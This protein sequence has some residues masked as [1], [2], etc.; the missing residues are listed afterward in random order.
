MTERSKRIGEMIRRG[1][2]TPRGV[3][4]IF[5]LRCRLCGLP[6]LLHREPVPAFAVWPLPGLSPGGDTS[7]PFPGLPVVDLLH[8]D[9]PYSLSGS[10]FIHE[11]YCGA[12]LGMTGSSSSSPLQSLHCAIQNLPEFFQTLRS[13]QDPAWCVCPVLS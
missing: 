13:S 5:L 10:L 9:P 12:A 7:C 4:G 8:Q 2:E 6:S 1:M 3:Q 11:P